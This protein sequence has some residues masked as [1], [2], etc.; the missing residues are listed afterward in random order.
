MIL[1]LVNL[2]QDDD[3]INMSWLMFWLSS[4]IQYAYKVQTP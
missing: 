2:L 4:D 3:F 1:Y